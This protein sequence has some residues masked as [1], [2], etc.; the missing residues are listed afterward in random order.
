M[1]YY[2]TKGFYVPASI[3]I[4][5]DFRVINYEI[6]G[7]DI[8][9]QFWD[10]GGSSYF[11]LYRS[12]YYYGASSM[13]LT[14]DLT[15]YTSF[16]GLGSYLEI[17]EQMG[18]NRE[19]ILLV[20][21]KMDLQDKRTVNYLQIEEFYESNNLAG[22]IETSA[23]T[24]ANIREAFE[25]STAIAL[26]AKGL[27]SKSEL[28]EFKEDILNSLI[29]SVIEIDDQ[30]V[31]QCFSCGRDLNFYELCGANTSMTP[32]DLKDLWESPHVQFYCCNCY[33]HLSPKQGF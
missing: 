26:R 22:Y 13:I 3:T 10:F 4:G 19:N 33:R 12:S 14:F 27:I 7:Q 28:D 18:I 6:F 2:L 32:E 21:C 11:D 24:G 16:E 20:G 29:D 5:I 23:R 25:L 8:S 15:R 1:L 9:T 30:I 31:K 17:C